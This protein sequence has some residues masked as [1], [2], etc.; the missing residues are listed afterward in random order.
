M[1]SNEGKGVVALA[2][3]RGQG[4]GELRFIDHVRIMQRLGDQVGLA[5]LNNRPDFRE[6]GEVVR[7][8]E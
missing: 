6:H 1:A 8:L 4:G 5:G 2:V 7:Q 3:G